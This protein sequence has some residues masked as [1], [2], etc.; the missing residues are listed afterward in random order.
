MYTSS[1][2][3]RAFLLAPL[4]LAASILPNQAAA[5]PVITYQGRIQAEGEPV[6]GIGQFKFAL[7]NAGT[8]TS[9]QATATATVTGGFVTSI[10]VNNPGAGYVVAPQVTIRDATGVG[11]VATAA[12]SGGQ[13][14]AIAVNNAGT[15]YSASPTVAI[16]PPPS[17]LN[18]VSYWS[19]DGT[20]ALGAEPTD[21]VAIVVSRGLFTAALGDASLP[22]MTP[23]PP[24]V[25]DNDD[26]HLRI[27]FNDGVNGTAQ[28]A[29]DQRITA[30]AFA[31]RADHSDSASLADVATTAMNVAWSDIS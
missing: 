7:V 25:F 11:A 13:I 24:S 30:S 22:N 29:G 3:F 31:I 18:F 27:W 4:L 10:T 8:E 6:D 28:L 19:N 2:A 1:P 15:G 14:S 20:S 9:V 5:P 23:I 16:D 26:V 12:L 21:A 17:N